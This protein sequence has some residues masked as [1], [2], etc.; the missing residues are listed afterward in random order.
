MGPVW[1][2]NHVWLIFALIICWSAFP[3]VFASVTST[4]AIPLFVAAIGI[5]LRGGAYVL[6][7][8]SVSEREQ[9]AVEAVFSVSSV[10]TPFALGTTVGAIGAREVPVGNAAGDLVSSWLNPTGLLA[11]TMAVVVAAYIAAVY[12]AADAVRVGRPDLA[13][14]F[15]VRALAAAGVAG[16]IALGGLVVVRSDA[17]DL[18]AGLT[19]GWGLVAVIVSML[20]G[21]AT[22]LLIWW[23][24]FEAA[25]LSASVAVTS[26]LLGWALALRP[27]LLPGLTLEE[28]AASRATLVAVIITL[29]L[30]VVILA[31]SLGLLFS[32]VLRG[33]FDRPPDKAPA[34]EV[35]GDG[36]VE[37]RRLLPATL[38][39]LAVGVPMLVLFEAAWAKTIGVAALMAF[40]AVG[41]VAVAGSLAAATA[42]DEPAAGGGPGGG[43]RG[44]GS[45]AL[46]LALG[47]LTV[48]GVLA[49]R[50]G[51]ATRG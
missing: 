7:S 1:E 51:R 10:I 8:G 43:R 30:G 40:I 50:R 33:T 5:I 18:W 45:R 26:I 2:A 27:E 34:G 29:A 49:L 23:S 24:R 38:G 13:Q 25:R 48:G 3:T 47:L 42:E 15:R 11:G 4:L 37:E 39:L 12:L 44:P 17:P 31:P 46:H 22:L 6:R 28:A 20:A 14:A 41:F 21:G 36:G 9:R 19:S 35:R 16:V 32:M